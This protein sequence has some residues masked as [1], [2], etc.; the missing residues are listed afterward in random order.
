MQ[1]VKPRACW[2]RYSKAFT[3]NGR[4][5]QSLE[6][7]TFRRSD[8]AALG[9]RWIAFHGINDERDPAQREAEKDQENEYNQACLIQTQC[10]GVTLWHLSSPVLTS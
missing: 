5:R 6:S 9:A 10:N 3:S 1:I 8:E 4:T 7:A 2:K